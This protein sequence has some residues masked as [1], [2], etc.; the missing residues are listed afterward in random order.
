MNLKSICPECKQ[1]HTYSD[2][3][4]RKWKD[5]AKWCQKHRREV[6]GKSMTCKYCSVEYKTLSGY[7]F[8]CSR[9][10]KLFERFGDKKNYER[11]KKAQAE[12]KK[13][14]SIEKEQIQQEAQKEENEELN[15]VEY[16]W[17]SITFFQG[18]HDR[19]VQPDHGLGF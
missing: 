13:L 6:F 18:P 15:K 16:S 14:E 3:T 19:I 12:T 1:E 5:K 11:L 9:H 8:C 17:T 2:F 7:P 10:Q 4:R